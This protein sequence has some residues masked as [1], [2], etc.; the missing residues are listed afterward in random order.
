[1]QIPQVDLKAQYQ[2][3][4]SEIDR[5]IAGVI[6]KTQFVRGDAVAEF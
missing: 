2:A 4:K 6:E 3:I 5:A 1:M